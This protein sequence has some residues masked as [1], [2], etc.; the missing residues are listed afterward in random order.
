MSHNV[1]VSA[2]VRIRSRV[3]SHETKRGTKIKTYSLH[4]TAPLQKHFVMHSAAVNRY[5]TTRMLVLWMCVGMRG[6]GIGVVFG[7]LHFQFVPGNHFSYSDRK[8]LTG[9][10]IDVLIDCKLIVIRVINRIAVSGAINIHHCK[11]IL[12][13]KLSNHLVIV[14]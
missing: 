1:C 3:L 2:V 5:L 13:A 4:A 11:F 9:F 12:K 6:T 14:R 8:L 7:G 10:I